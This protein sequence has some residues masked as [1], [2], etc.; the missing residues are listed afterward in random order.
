MEMVMERNKHGDGKM[1]NGNIDIFHFNGRTSK[2][3]KKGLRWTSYGKKA[4]MARQ[5]C[6]VWQES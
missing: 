4:W 3:T 1:C 2:L 5:Q 6:N